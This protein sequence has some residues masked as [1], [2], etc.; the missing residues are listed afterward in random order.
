MCFVPLLVLEDPTKGNCKAALPFVHSDQK[1]EL[2][3]YVNVFSPTNGSL[4]TDYTSIMM[5]HR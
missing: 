2:T 3:G 1:W 5:V 4:M